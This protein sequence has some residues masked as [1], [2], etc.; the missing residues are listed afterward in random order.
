MDYNFLYITDIHNRSEKDRPEGRTD[1]YYLSVLKKQEEIGDI[2]KSENI[3]F[4]LFGG[5]LFH[6]YDAPLGLI[7]DVL[8]IWKSYGVPIY[9]CIGS[10][11]Y[12]GYQIKTL[13]RTAIGI[14]I[15]NNV[16][17]IVGTGNDGFP[18]FVDISKNIRITATPHTIHLADKASNF[19]TTECGDSK[20][21]IQLVHGDL[22]NVKVSW[23]HQL[24]D[25]VHEYIIADLVLSGHIHAGWKNPIIKYNERSFSK[26]TLYINPGSIGRTQI[27]PIRPIRVFKFTINDNGELVC[28]KYI[29]LKNVNKYPFLK[30][31][32][33][34]DGSP[35][36]DFSEFMNKLSSM[37]IDK[38]DIKQHVP[39]IV[40]QLYE[41]YST[42]IKDRITRNTIK[43]LEE[44]KI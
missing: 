38:Q 39:L 18:S 20:F 31:T 3:D 6:H 34:V 43:I 21:T 24:I 22:F 35:V 4:L 16:I 33:Q 42:D 29:N 26:K 19:K 7:N 40:E 15:I 9:G 37:K 11:D 10:H 14:F 1:N 44:A 27:G 28:Y 41:S 12:S 8:K 32:N 5:D 30:K 23:K 25:N 36:I 13:R 17:S 2:I